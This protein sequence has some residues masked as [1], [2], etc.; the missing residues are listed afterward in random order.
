M[1][2]SFSIHQDRVAIISISA[3]HCLIWILL[4]G[5]LPTTSC[6]ME[7][8]NSDEDS[9]SQQSL[10]SSQASASTSVETAETRSRYKR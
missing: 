2:I 8:G 3:V 6:L 10:D 9:G 5:Y 1:T 4:I 7:G